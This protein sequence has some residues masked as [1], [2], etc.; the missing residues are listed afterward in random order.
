MSGSIASFWFN[1]VTYDVKADADFN[2]NPEEE[3]EGIATSGDSLFKS[4]RQ[5]ATVDG[6]DLIVD[7]VA[8]Q[9]LRQDVR[10]KVLANGGYEE[11]DGTVNNATCRLNIV[12]RTT[13][14]N[15]MSVVLIPKGTWEVTP[16]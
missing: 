4:T 16:A 7:G 15:T 10:D 14:E 12:G 3:V 1:G 8:K 2:E 11:E 13:Q 6:I 9:A 5:V